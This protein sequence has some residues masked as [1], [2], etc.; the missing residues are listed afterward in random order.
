MSNDIRIGRIESNQFIEV[1]L[2]SFSYSYS[3][4]LYCV[5]LFV[6]NHYAYFKLKYHAKKTSS[7][8]L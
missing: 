7:S 3:S 2:N 1:I 4:A 5:V 8:R 6:C